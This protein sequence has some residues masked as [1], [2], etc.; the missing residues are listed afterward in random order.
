MA[1][2]LPFPMFGFSK[3]RICLQCQERKP[4]TD[5]HKDTKSP[6]GH[7]K[8]CRECCNALARQARIRTETP[9]DT[10]KEKKAIRQ[11]QKARKP[12]IAN[13][14]HVPIQSEERTLETVLQELAKQTHFSLS[15]AKNGSIRL[16]QHFHHETRTYKAPDLQSLLSK[17]R[18][19]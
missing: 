12:V 19:V 8:R 13:I 2:F 18:M 16:Q 3:D 1:P 6:D 7:R 11:P 17:V 10:R 5:F 15:F 9:P 14:T 4:L